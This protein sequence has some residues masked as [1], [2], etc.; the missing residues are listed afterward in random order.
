M[1]LPSIKT[2]IPQRRYQYGEFIITVLGDIES[3]D[4]VRYRYLMAVATEADPTPG[5]F[6]SCERSGQ[7][8]FT[9]RVSMADGSQ[10]LGEST[11]LGDQ[12]TFVR[13]ALKIVATMLDLSDEVPH[14][15][16]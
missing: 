12:E 4:P 3:D 11:A 14:R 15:L 8:G 16:M 1:S 9:L 13:E 5:L 7:E 10:V 2:A 6:L